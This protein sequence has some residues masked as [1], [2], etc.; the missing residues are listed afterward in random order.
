MLTQRLIYY[1]VLCV[2]ARDHENK[3]ESIYSLTGLEHELHRNYQSLMSNY[4]TA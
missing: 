2:I 3:E 1:Y 4:F